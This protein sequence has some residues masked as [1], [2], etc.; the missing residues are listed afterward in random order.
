MYFEYDGHQKTVVIEPND[1]SK[2]DGWPECISEETDLAKNLAG[3][4][5]GDQVDVEIGIGVQK[6][7]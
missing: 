3:L 4:S 1:V 7:R 5:I 6:A 2:S